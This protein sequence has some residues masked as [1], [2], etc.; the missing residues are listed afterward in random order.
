MKTRRYFKCTVTRT[1]GSTFENPLML[2]E[3]PLIA[4]MIRENKSVIPEMIEVS[5]E[6]YDQIFRL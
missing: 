4:K 2:S 6:Q 1:D 3:E 5:A